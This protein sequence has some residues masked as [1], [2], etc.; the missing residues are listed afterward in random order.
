METIVTGNGRR[1]VV[2]AVMVYLEWCHRPGKLDH[3]LVVRLDHFTFSLN[4]TQHEAA[5]KLDY[6]C[7]VCVLHSYSIRRV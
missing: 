3:E 6:K 2:V 1:T 5:W 7:S 4:R